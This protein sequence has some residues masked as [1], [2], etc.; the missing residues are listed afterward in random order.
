MII[1]LILLAFAVLTGNQPVDSLVP[2]EA[3]AEIA[4]PASSAPV[5][6]AAVV[7]ARPTLPAAPVTA[8]VAAL[9]APAP[10]FLQPA[11]ASPGSADEV[12]AAVQ[13]FYKKTPHL[14]AK[15][16]QT[17]MNATF[18]IPKTNDG[19][20]YLKKP[21]KMRWDYYSKRQKGQPLRTQLSDGKTAWNIDYKGKWYYRQDLSQSALPVAVTFLTGKG[22]LSKEF[23]AELDTRGK[24]GKKGDIV[25]ALTP[26]KP[27][28]QF[29]TLYLVVDAQSKR[30]KQSIVINAAGD[31]NMFSFYEPNASK[32]VTDQLFVFNPKA[33]AARG[34][35][36]IKPPQGP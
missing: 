27:S 32:T 13:D 5:T 22:E 31:T 25:L 23:N 8:P 9:V 34:F 24:Y 29:K 16:R 2:T 3:Q 20:V 1:K 33:T 17:T 26:K 4:P 36:Q 12:V 28:A 7:K 15:F 30:V 35:R 21:G 19:K 11:V 14:T 18:G 10:V 6:K